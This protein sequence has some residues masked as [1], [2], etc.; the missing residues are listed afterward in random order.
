MTSH[1][2]PWYDGRPYCAA[3]GARA[4]ECDGTRRGGWER[5]GRCTA[6]GSSGCPRQPRVWSAS[7]WIASGRRWRAPRAW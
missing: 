6:L 4:T 5:S 7:R 1:S 2:A 3:W